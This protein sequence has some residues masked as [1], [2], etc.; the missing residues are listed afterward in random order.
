MEEVGRGWRKLKDIGGWSSE[1][2]IWR[3]MKE[4][5]QGRKLEDGSGWKMEVGRGWRRLE[6][7][8]FWRRLDVE[9]RTEVEVRGRGEVKGHSLCFCPEVVLDTQLLDQ[10]HG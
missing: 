9:R 10:H 3:R 2:E 7:F 5:G 1:A 8:G 6:E 4:A